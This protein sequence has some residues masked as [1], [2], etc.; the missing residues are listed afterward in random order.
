M[1]LKHLSLEQ[2]QDLS[3]QLPELQVHQ[4]Y[5]LVLQQ[6]RGRLDQAQRL[7][8]AAVDPLEMARLQGECKAL[9]AQAASVDELKK[10]LKLEIEAR[11]DGTSDEPL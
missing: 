2:L 10:Q 5:L 6:C 3:S 7:L 11:R 1:D 9:R 8:E 4:C